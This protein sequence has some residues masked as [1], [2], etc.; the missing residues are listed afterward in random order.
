M[1]LVQ[2]GFALVLATHLARSVVDEQDA[3]SGAWRDRLASMP[4]TCITASRGEEDTG[5]GCSGSGA[6]RSCAGG[7]FDSVHRSGYGGKER[8]I[9]SRG[10]LTQRTAI[11]LP[12]IFACCST[13]WRA[14]LT[15]SPLLKKRTPTW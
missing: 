4:V 5:F 15:T 6:M 14:T 8:V 3:A 11:G 9:R 10:S 1:R 7:H 12:T 2:A 13:T